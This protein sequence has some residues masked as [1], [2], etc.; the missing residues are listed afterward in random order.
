VKEQATELIPDALEPTC[1][2][3]SLRPHQRKPISE[4]R[5]NDI[6]DKPLLESPQSGVIA[7]IRCKDVT[8]QMTMSRSPGYL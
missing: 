5:S 1:L 4:A 3:A 7:S 6:L 2:V 8:E